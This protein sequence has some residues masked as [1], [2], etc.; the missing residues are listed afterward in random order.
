VV[1]DK[2]KEEDGPSKPVPSEK[3]GLKD[4]PRMSIRVEKNINAANGETEFA[5]DLHGDKPF[6]KILVCGYLEQMMAIQMH[7]LSLLV[8]IGHFMIN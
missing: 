4:S 1:D 7:L 6:F 3:G 2:E 5:G 8:L